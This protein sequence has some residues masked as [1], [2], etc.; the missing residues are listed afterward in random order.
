MPA[1]SQT[2]SLK[3]YMSRFMAD[4]A[5]RKKWPSQKQRAAVGYSEFRKRK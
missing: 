2:E 1:P 4:K 3:S 5:D